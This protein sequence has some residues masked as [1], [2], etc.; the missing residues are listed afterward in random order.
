MDCHR[1]AATG[2]YVSLSFSQRLSLQ[3]PL[4]LL[5]RKCATWAA[6]RQ[7]CC[8]SLTVTLRPRAAGTF[9]GYCELEGLQV[10]KTSEA[11]EL[12]RH[13]P[14]FLHLLYI[15]LHLKFY[16]TLQ[17][18]FKEDIMKDVHAGGLAN[19]NGLRGQLKLLDKL[20]CSTTLDWGARQAEEEVGTTCAIYQNLQI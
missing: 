20:G 7:M 17:W 8:L 10:Q 13:R 6:F 16:Y 2:L 11:E 5:S 9:P 4:D 19:Q 14:N 15:G 1:P 12:K 3:E 18:Q